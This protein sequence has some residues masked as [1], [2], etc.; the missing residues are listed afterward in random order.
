MAM[1]NHFHPLVV[2]LLLTIFPI[3]ARAGGTFTVSNVN[4]SGGG[5]LR[6]A[7]T[8]VNA[9]GSATSTNTVDFTISNAT[10]TLNTGVLPTIANPVSIKNASGGSVTIRADGNVGLDASATISLTGTNALNLVVNSAATAYGI[11]GS[12]GTGSDLTIATFDTNATVQATAT[13]NAGVAYGLF[14]NKNITISNGLSGTVLATSTGTGGQAYGLLAAGGSLNGGSATT[15]LSISGTVSAAANGLAVAVGASG[16]MNLTVTGTLSGVDTSGGGA[17]YA[18][19]AGA[20][21]GA[22]GWV[23]GSADN[24]VTLATGANLIGIVDLGAGNNTLALVGTG[25]AS[26]RFI[27]VTNLVAGNSGGT[28]TSWVLNPSAANA[29]VFGNLTI[30]PNASLSLN[31]NVTITGNILDNGALI[32]DLAADKTYAG[33]ISGVGSLTKTG[34]GTLYLRGNNTYSGGTSFNGG[35]IN[36]VSDANLGDPSGGLT[37]NGGTLQVS[38]DV[39]SNRSITLNSNGGIF[40]TNG[41]NL[42]LN[43]TITGV[44]ALTKTSAGTLYLTGANT[45]TGGTNINGGVVNIVSDANLGDPSGGVTLSGGTLQAGGP[46]TTSRI[47]TVNAGGGTLDNAGNPVTLAGTLTG[48]GP[49]TFTGAAATTLTGNGSGY[50]GAATLA[51]GTLQVASGAS[52]GG[53][54]TVNAGATLG[55]YGTVNNVV[56]NGLVSPGGSIGTLH[57]SGNYTQGTT[58]SYYDE[59]SPDWSGDL[60]AVSG[61]A[62]LCGGLLSVQAPQVYYPTGATW[63][64]ITAAAGVSGNFA[65]VRQNLLSP[66]LVFVPVTT[67]NAVILTTIRIPYATYALDGRSASV[68][69]GLAEAATFG[70]GDMASLL[71]TLDYSPPAVTTYTLGLLS[72]EPYDA[73]TQGIFDAG[74]LLTA[75]QRVELHG[76]AHSG[77][78]A[79]SGPLDTGPAALM[80]LNDLQNGQSLTT[81]RHGPG[82]V[83]GAERMEASQFDVFLHPF[84]MLANQSAGSERTGYA[85][86]TGGLTGGLVSHPQSGLTLGLAPGYFSQSVKIKT[87]GGA[88]ATVN[89]WSLAMLAAY[90]R[91]DWFVDGL[92]REG[93][94]TVTA[95]RSLPVPN[96]VRA[97]RAVWSGWSTTAGLSGGYDFH[98]GNTTLGPVASLDWQRLG[99][100]A[101]SETRAGGLGLTVRG[102]ADHALTTT[103]GGRIYRNFETKFGTVTP[104]IRLAWEAQWLGAPRTIDASFNGYAQS[105]FSTRTSRHDY[106]A[107]LVDTGMS[108]SMSKTLSVSARFGVELFRPGYTAQAASVG[109]KYAF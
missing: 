42:T 25:S 55:G 97:A 69:A 37:F 64:V 17:G 108:V 12:A 70:Y 57:L 41:S 19:R 71:T 105:G 61:S 30:Y 73:V 101:Y 34:S 36:I 72:P 16:A 66:T 80:A 88:N 94:D 33:V 22:G 39:V 7:I 107:A 104:E 60:L 4:D 51:A 15:P 27:G 21:D 85:T 49:F 24:T 92:I 29:S 83:A 78:A 31:E 20:P 76:G 67:G 58:G 5:S 44:G 26:N 28:A 65:A 59:I 38:A 2:V 82:N 3:C 47:L 100:S 14:A 56:N 87:V 95:N 46:L 68:G 102:R 48:S 99:Q 63:T 84:G 18:I 53:T 11:T 81:N 23:T 35:T 96:M 106:N 13:G 109:L 45:Y 74:R 32:F 10:I 8:N 90:R 1:N 43:G 50:S 86:T 6:Q 9:T 75:A 103:L 79:F 91:G 77:S 89:D 98:L 40:D 62:T 93:Y 52:L 54:L